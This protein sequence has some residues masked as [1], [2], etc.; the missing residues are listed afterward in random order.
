M[1]QHDS[2]IDNA[3]GAAFRADINS[4]LAALFSLNSGA[5]APTFTV[6]YMLWADTSTGVLKIRNAA[7]SAWIN[8]GT[9]ASANLGMLPLAGGN[10]TGAVNDKGFTVAANATTTDIW[11]GG[12][13]C[14][15]T[16]AAVTFTDVADAPIADAW[17]WVRSNAAHTLTNNANIQVQGNANL[18]LAA[19][20]MML[21][22][23]ITTTT[24]E[25]W[26]FKDD[27]TA[28]VGSSNPVTTRVVTDTSDIVLALAAA[29]TQSNVGSTFSVNI[30]ATGYIELAAFAGRILNNATASVHK[31]CFGIR[32]GT[33]NYWFGQGSE[34]GTF[35]VK[36]C[37]DSDTTASAY[38]EINGSPF[39]AK[40][41]TTI[42]GATPVIDIVALGVPTG[43]QT[44]Q[45]IAGY[46]T[47][48]VTLKGTV[49]TTRA[50]LAFVTT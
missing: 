21:W 34:N 1:A 48:T 24:F 27:G 45:F 47:N 35:N 49:K 36:S 25:V 3:N 17:R 11:T 18:T 30:P 42:D 39:Y 32:I 5:S 29:G 20:D 6:A 13:F 14:T 43:V 10:L 38:V 44:V 8:L 12:N 31:T 28:V 26:I 37:I 7:N 9:M 22:H 33:T 23:A 4:A 40:S 19:G 46:Q 50:T 15:L 41:A 2:V 16:G